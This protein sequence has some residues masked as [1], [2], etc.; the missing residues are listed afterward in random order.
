MPIKE[1]T[2]STSINDYINN[3]SSIDELYR[4]IDKC[5][6][7]VEIMKKAKLTNLIEQINDLLK[8]LAENYPWEISPFCDSE[9][10]EY[11][12]NEIPEVL[13]N[14]LEELTN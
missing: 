13:E 14:Y 10:A 1:A 7:K 11:A 3:C 8:E 9:G 5:K 12:W 4:I 6:N 2:T